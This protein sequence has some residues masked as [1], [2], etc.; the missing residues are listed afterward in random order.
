MDEIRQRIDAARRRLILRQWAGR[1]AVCLAVAFGAALVAI[2][3]PK[4]VAVAGL[5]AAWSVWWLVGAAVIG[6]AAATVWTALDNRSPL[7]AAVEIDKRFGLRERVAS[8]LSLTEEDFST[9][10]GAA[11]ARDARRAIDRVEVSE[12]FR[13]GLNRTAWLPVA[14]AVVAVLLAALVSNRTASATADTPDAK[15]AVAEQIKKVA[16]ESR[17]KLAERRKKAEEEGLADASALLKKVEEGTGE[18]AKKDTKD[19][20][21]TAVK[22]NDLTQQLAERKQ[23]LGGGDEL[24]DQLNRMKDLGKGPADKAADAM[25]QGDW[26]KALDEISKL[27]EKIASGKLSPEEQEQLADQLGK[28]KE[29]L[30]QAAQQQAA[31]KK[32]LE[33]QLADAQ[34][35]GDLQQAGKLQQKLDQLAQK[36]PQMQALEQLAQKM[37]E[38]QQCMKQGDGQQAAQAM[39][40]LAQQMQQLQKQA[41]EMEML[42]AAMTDIQMAKQA[43]GMEAQQLAQMMGPA[44]PNQQGKPGQGMGEGRGEGA[45][46][47]EENDVNFRDSQV[48]QN[49]GRG[50]STFGG[51]VEGPSIKGEVAESIKTGLSA[52]TVEPADPLVSERLPKSRQE[53]AEEYFRGLRERL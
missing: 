12:Q 19:K 51:L 6:L 26:K 10:A 52:D 31:Q 21:E 37:G 25:K 22:L 29:K 15:Q 33:R 7:D 43:M 38:C 20:T 39:Q 27:S 44:P 49:V 41:Q 50:A 35:K 23:K 40:Q 17:K 53:H 47:S 30:Q 46:P 5:P 11:L 14:P 18:I 8:T 24:R 2:A 13:F 16:E 48:K 4:L 34:R 32:E 3:V 1:L 45:R 9:E 28:M 42:D 36:A